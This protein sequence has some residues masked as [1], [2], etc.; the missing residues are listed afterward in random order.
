MPGEAEQAILDAIRLLVN[1]RS[2]YLKRGDFTGVHKCDADLWALHRSLDILLV[3]TQ[4]ADA[5]PKQ[6]T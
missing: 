3:T 2:M 4:E 1:I 6:E 5:A